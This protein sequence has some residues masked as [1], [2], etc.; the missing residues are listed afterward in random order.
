[1]QNQTAGNP[2]IGVRVEAPPSPGVPSQPATQ[3]LR[4][5]CK[6]LLDRLG[7]PQD[8]DQ[9]TTPP[10]DLQAFLAAL[11]ATAQEAVQHGAHRAKEATAP[12]QPNAPPYPPLATVTKPNLTTAEIAYYAN[13]AQ[14]TWRIHACRETFPP[15]LR[16]IRIGGRLN[17]PTAGAKKLMGVPA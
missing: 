3:P 8:T 2:S 9:A 5:L 1:M 10:T 12:V 15:G 16:P 14:Q 13:Q 17:W 6:A 11:Q 4:Q 7:Q